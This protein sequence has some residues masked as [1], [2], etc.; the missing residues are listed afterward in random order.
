M[1]IEQGTFIETSIKEQLYSP[2]ECV[3]CEMELHCV[4]SPVVAT[5]AAVFARVVV[6]GAFALKLPFAVAG[7]T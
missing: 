2:P 6:F 7:G 5:V 4:V 1:H 3:T